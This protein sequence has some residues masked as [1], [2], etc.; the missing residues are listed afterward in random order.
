[1]VNEPPADTRGAPAP[2]ACRHW[3][4]ILLFVSLVANVFLL[5]LVG[6][7]ILHRHGWM[8][9]EAAYTQQFGPMAGH[10]LMRVLA[11]LDAP[12]RKIVLDSVR[13]HS[14]ELQKISASI[15]EQR[16]V[17]AQ[18]LKAEPFERKAVDDAFTELRRRSDSMLAV[19]QAALGDA[20]EK[21][22]PDARKRLED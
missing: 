15:R 3:P 19:L 22:P 4:T 2:K 11:P 9:G 8:D 18:L 20:V 14:D 12:D 7:R 10:A 6:G 16:K 21:L 13:S 5:G 17:V 1:M